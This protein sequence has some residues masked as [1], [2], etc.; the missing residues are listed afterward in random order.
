[1]KSNNKAEDAWQILRIQG[2]FTKGFDQLS[3]LGPC[4]SIFGSAR[5]KEDNPHYKSAEKMA[6]LCN[7]NGFG[8]ITGGGPGI[9]EA[10]NKGAYKSDEGSI[11]LSIQ[12]PFEATANDYIDKLVDCRYFFTRKVFFLKY[13]QAFIGY[14]GGFGT[15]DELFETLTL[16]QCGHMREVPVVL[17]GSDYWGGIVD[18]MKKTMYEKEGNLSEKDFD[19]FKVVDTPEDAISYILNN[20]ESDKKED[21]N[22]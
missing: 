3:E 18:W 4:I 14:P 9:M 11:G 16:I 7:Q 22:F 2:E 21:I 12:L 10:A 17:V 6:K 20:I 13:A 5:T 15:L 8:V 1:M 19:L